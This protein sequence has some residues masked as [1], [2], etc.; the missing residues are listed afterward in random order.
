M[1]GHLQHSHN[2]SSFMYVAQPTELDP[3]NIRYIKK[4]SLII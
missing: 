1:L 4:P 2:P 3:L